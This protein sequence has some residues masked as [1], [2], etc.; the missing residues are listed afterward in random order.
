[1]CLCEKRIINIVFFAGANAFYFIYFMKL[2][3]S[4]KEGKGHMNSTPSTDTNTTLK[5]LALHLLRKE[6]DASALSTMSCH[7]KLAA[8]VG[9]DKIEYDTFIAS[10]VWEHYCRARVKQFPKILSHVL[11]LH[12]EKPT[13]KILICQ[14]AFSTGLMYAGARVDNIKGHLYGANIVG[15]QWARLFNEIVANKYMLHEFHADQ[16][17]GPCFPLL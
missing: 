12:H 10:K 11:S 14:L 3:V 17:A 2:F 15:V 6:L 1:M 9:E 4:L 13:H 16:V 7:F 8:F 5:T